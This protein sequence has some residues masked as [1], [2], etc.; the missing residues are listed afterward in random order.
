MNRNAARIKSLAALLVIVVVA[1][2]GSPAPT[3]TVRKPTPSRTPIRTA[4][5][6]P[7]PHVGR[8]LAASTMKSVRSQATATL[9]KDGRVLIVGG[10]EFGKPLAT[11]E[12][13]DPTTG[14]FTATGSMSVARDGH[15]ATLL[16]D[17]RVL[18]AGGSGDR[19]VEIYTPATGRFTRT[20]STYNSPSYQAAALLN[21]GRVLIAGGLSSGGYTSRGQTYKPS[22]GRFSST[23]N[24]NDARENA[25]A[26]TLPDGRV[27]IA[28]GDRGITGPNATILATAEIF[29]PS[30]GTF[31]RTAPMNYARTHFTATLLPNGKVLVV[32][33][34]SLTSGSGLLSSAEIYDPA[35][36]KWTQTGSMTFGRSDFTAT[37]LADGRVLVAGGGDSS[38]ELYN[39][40]T[41]K[42]EMAAPMILPREFQTA[43]L[44]N[45]T[46]VLL[47]GGNDAKLA[48][49]YWP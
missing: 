7:T 3:A 27:L 8:F 2:C 36:G 32:G 45:D 19:S 21:D 31:K 34:D 24:L 20:D 28:G 17:G 23:R 41:G 9:L 15:T 11:A 38:A 22:R 29:N 40:A 43:T 4:K 33:G 10:L 47:A 30:T 12:I 26:T 48:E 37:L 14:A 35:A 18:V 13:Y 16:P 25:T 44:L 49:L 1:S 5:P 42:F 46:R 6:T 39:P